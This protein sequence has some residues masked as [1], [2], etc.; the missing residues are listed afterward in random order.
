MT[1]EFFG[2]CD[3]AATSRSLN[4]VLKGCSRAAASTATFVARAH[5]RVR[6]AGRRARP[7]SRFDE[8]ERSRG[9]SRADMERFA[10]LYAR[11]ARAVLVWSMGIT[12]HAHGVDNVAADREPGLARGNVGRDGAGLMPIRG[13]SG[14][15]G[16]AEMGAYAT[17]LPGWR[18]RDARERGRARRAVGL[19]RPRRAR[20]HRRR[21][22]RGGRAGRARRA[23]LHR[24]QL[25][26]GAAR[27]AGVEAALARVPLRVH[28]DIVALQPDAGR[29]GRR[30]RAAAGGHPLRAARRRHRDHHRAAHR[31]QPRDPRAAG[32]G[33]PQRVGDLRRPR[34]PGPSRARPPVA[35]ASGQAIRDEIARAV[36]VYAGVELLA[37]TGDA[38]QWGGT[39]LCEGGDFPTPDGR[40]RFLAVRPPS[41]GRARRAASCSA[42][43]AASSSTPW[44]TRTETRSRGDA[45]RAVHG[46]DDIRG[47]G[48]ADG[49]RVLVRSTDGECSRASTRAGFG[50]ATSR[51]SSPRATCCSRAAGATGRRASPTTTRP[52]SSFR[53]RPLFSSSRP[54]L[55]VVVLPGLVRETDP[56]MLRAPIGNL[57]ENPCRMGSRMSLRYYEDWSKAVLGR[58]TRPGQGLEGPASVD[59]SDGPRAGGVQGVDSRWQVVGDSVDQPCVVFLTNRA[60]YVDVW[61]YEGG[62]R[63]GSLHHFDLV[64]QSAESTG[65]TLAALASPSSSTRRADRD[66]ADLRSIA[67]DLPRD[68]SMALPSGNWSSIQSEHVQARRSDGR[69]LRRSSGSRRNFVTAEQA[70]LPHR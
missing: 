20:P 66:R 9:A 31:L 35:F 51:C 46:A 42:P 2:R 1:D 17:A 11:R 32:R 16:G 34:P 40:A 26:R 19:R 37:T 23:L 41:A 48:L 7:R 49:D 57:F 4:G 67:V 24:R 22:G 54:R 43:A 10:R 62:T 61:P 12:Q 44:C 14:V 55:R 70:A 28:Q 52:S 56:S 64:A 6:R 25:P 13:H 36:P 5:R 47:L 39:R 3:R 27:P 63:A 45:G 30:R 38:V 60:L 65:T 15:Q 18:P 69:I 33:G 53:N 50:P 21:D 68:R 59:G 58:R 8:L 29:P